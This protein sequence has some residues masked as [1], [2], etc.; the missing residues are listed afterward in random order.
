MKQYFKFRNDSRYQGEFKA[1]ETGYFICATYQDC[2][3]VFWIVTKNG[4][5]GT[6]PSNLEPI[7]NIND[8]KEN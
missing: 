1:G 2:G 8:L 3:P 5:H 4:V 7:E 6:N